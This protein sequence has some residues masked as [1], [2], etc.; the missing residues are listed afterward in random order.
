MSNL[1]WDITSVMNSVETSAYDYRT[2]TCSEYHR[3]K[4]AKQVK[5]GLNWLK[6]FDP[7]NY[8]LKDDF[9]DIK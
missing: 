3:K 1:E 8:L 9:T 4:Y 2:A 5:N 7:N 6:E